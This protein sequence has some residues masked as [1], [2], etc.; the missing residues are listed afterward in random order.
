MA[1][2]GINIHKAYIATEVEQLIDVFY[3]LDS[4]GQKLNDEDFRNEVIQGLMHSI[5]RQR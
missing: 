3:V 5:N 4:N 1:D 2:F